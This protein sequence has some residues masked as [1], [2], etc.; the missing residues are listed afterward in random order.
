M[1]EVH[2]DR[3]ETLYR[4]AVD[5][6]DQARSWFDGPGTAWRAS[7]PSDG[8]AAV[9]TESLATTSRL[10]GVMAWLLDPAQMTGDQCPPL[11]I[12]DDGTDLPAGSPLAGTPGGVV[13]VAARQLVRDAAALAS[14]AGMQGRETPPAQPD[15]AV[16]NLPDADLP[17]QPDAGPVIDDPTPKKDY[18]GL[19]RK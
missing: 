6:G 15:V 4:Q 1:G 2:S 10:L 9:A 5:L 12:S 8:R 14:V 11:P 18:F 3:L 17:A 13:A 16:A 19:W 7:L